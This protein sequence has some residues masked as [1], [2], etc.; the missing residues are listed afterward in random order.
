M[1][2][3]SVH[4]SSDKDYWETPSKIYNPLDNEFNFYLDAAASEENHKC[5]DY[6]TESHDSLNQDWYQHFSIFVNPPYGRGLKYWIKKASD[7]AEMGCTVVM[8]IPNRPTKA[9]FDY[10]YERVDGDY[11]YGGEL[12]K[13]VEL[14]PLEK[15]IVFEIDGKPVLDKKGKPMP[16]PFPSSIVI[17]RGD[18]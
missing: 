3:L 4:H 13:G 7:E 14:R 5:A 8:L 9:W 17:F 1:S 11:S 15:R 6:Y 18:E 16:A 2:N 10:I 12:R